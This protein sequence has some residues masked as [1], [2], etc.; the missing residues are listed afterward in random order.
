M[1]SGVLA[2]A[3]A[4]PALGFVVL[5]ATRWRYEST[6]RRGHCMLRGEIARMPPRPRASPCE[7]RWGACDVSRVTILHI[8]GLS[9]KARRSG[10]GGGGKTWSDLCHARGHSFSS[11]G[12]G[13]P[14]RALPKRGSNGVRDCWS[15]K[16]ARIAACDAWGRAF[17]EAAAA[18]VIK[19]K[20]AV[21]WAAKQPLS[22][23]DVEVAPPKA[24][25][26]RVKLMAS[27]VCHT[28]AY[29]LSGADP[30]GAPR[31]GRWSGAACPP[32]SLPAPYQAF[33]PSSS[34]TRAAAWWRASA[35]VRRW[36]PI[37]ARRRHGS[38][39]HT[40][41]RRDQRGGG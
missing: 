5:A 10:P 25:E 29:T 26:V 37:R 16:A 28:D 3:P 41:H 34:A 18:Q 13:K 32:H 39:R 2:L 27:G 1:G 14:N 12:T 20:A 30:E 8:G 36:Q 23:E 17:D 15:G 19:C 6:R 40:P 9:G 33:S 31:C 22:L 21:A 11:T 35:K 38:G 4:P 7:A 24:G